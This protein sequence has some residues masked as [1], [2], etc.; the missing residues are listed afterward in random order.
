MGN[1]MNRAERQAIIAA[2]QRDLLTIAKESFPKHCS[3]GR[4]YENLDE[5]IAGTE[6]VEDGR[7][8]FV[9]DDYASGSVVDLIR[10]CPCG[11]TLMVAFETR[12]DHSTGGDKCRT[13][14]GQLHEFFTACGLDAITVRNELLKTAKGEISPLLETAFSE[15]VMNGMEKDFIRLQIRALRILMKK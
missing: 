2:M 5:F 15:R 10:N 1:K 6:S 9:D 11:S 4:S 7:G 12:R 14:F 13:I 3:C 8:L